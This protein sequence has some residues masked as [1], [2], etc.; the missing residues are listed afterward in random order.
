MGKDLLIRILQ[1]QL[2]Q[3]NATV[4]QLNDTVSSLNATIADLH[5]TIDNLDSLL[6]ERDKN[7][8][9][10][11][12]QMRGLKATFLPKQSEKQTQPAAPK[13]EEQKEAEKQARR[14]KIKARGNNG[15]KRKDH[16]AIEEILEPG[17][18]MG[19]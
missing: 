5:K 1:D 18:Q 3:S 17:S 12:A 10:S 9:K 16:F 8:D 2:E 7:L 6:K 11:N 15:A 13:T 19:G 14:E 4:R